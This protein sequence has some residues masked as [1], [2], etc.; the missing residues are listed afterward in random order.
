M[1]QFRPMTHPRKFNIALWGLGG[2]GKTYTGLALAHQLGSRVAVV[3]TEHEASALYAAR[4]PSAIVAL[5]PPYTPER[6]LEAIHAAETAG[7]EVVMLDS[8]S[9]EW[10][11]PGGCLSLQQANK[12][13]G[14]WKEINDRHEALLKAINQTPL[15]VIVTFREKPRVI[16]GKDPDTGKA[17]VDKGDTTPITRERYD[18]EYDLV[19]HLQPTHVATATKSRLLTFRQGTALPANGD[20]LALVRTAMDPDSTL[21]A[22]AVSE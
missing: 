9:P 6:Y 5:D 2:S 3:D 13:P 21:P 8:L 18:Y 15:S 16:F 7:F 17:V 22:S 14:V 11:G 1:F 20:L 19:L 12:K 10:D 4:F